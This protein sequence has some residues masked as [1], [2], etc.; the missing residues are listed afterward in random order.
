VKPEQTDVDPKLA[1][2]GHEHVLWVSGPGYSVFESG[3]RCL[4]DLD[5]GRDFN[6][7]NPFLLSALAASSTEPGE[8]GAI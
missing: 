7:D 2:V 6:L 8:E 4:V 1:R 5:R 3:D